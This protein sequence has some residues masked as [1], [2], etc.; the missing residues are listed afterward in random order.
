MLCG[1][2]TTGCHGAIEAADPA[3]RAA[4]GKYLRIHRPDVFTYLAEK[5]RREGGAI[6]ASEWLRRNLD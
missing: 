3:A 4:L 2:G 6:A 5:M 1:D